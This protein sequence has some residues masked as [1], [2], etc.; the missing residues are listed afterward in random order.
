MY[1]VPVPTSQAAAVLHSRHTH[2]FC[3][4]Q[5]KRNPLANTKTNVKVAK[6]VSDICAIPHL[7]SSCRQLLPRF[8]IFGFPILASRSSSVHRSWHCHASGTSSPSAMDAAESEITSAL[9]ESDGQVNDESGSSVMSEADEPESGDPPSRKELMHEALQRLQEQDLE[10]AMEKYNLE[11]ELFAEIDFSRIN[12]FTDS[13]F[14]GNPAVVCYLPLPRSSE[15][16]QLIAHEFNV[17]ATAFLVKRRVPT[18]K[19]K[20][21]ALPKGFGAPKRPPLLESNEEGEGLKATK[22]VVESSLKGNEFDLR[23]FSSTEELQFCGHATLA[24]AHLLFSA[25][26]IE[27]DTVQFHTQKGVLSA[28]RVNDKEGKGPPSPGPDGRGPSGGLGPQNPASRR[29]TGR[30]A[31]VLDLPLEDVREGTKEETAAVREALPGVDVKWVGRSSL[32][33]LVELASEADI[34][35]FQ[36]G[37]ASVLLAPKL[38]LDG[39]HRGFSVTAA[40]TSEKGND[41]VSRFF[42]PGPGEGSPKED[43]VTGSVHCALAGHWAKRLSKNEGLQAYQASDRG[44]QLRLSVNWESKR[45]SLEGSALIV[46]AGVLFNT[47]T[48]NMPSSSPPASPSSPSVLSPSSP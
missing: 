29:T 17:P 4:L 37:Q 23:W 45:V 31:Y 7:D 15:W 21:R 42:S 11:E 34:V 13:P 19:R 46:M 33:L 14:G 32:D 40:A 1:S 28:Q 5:S 18:P 2:F 44:G 43:P 16:M 27:E 30:G 24:S 36:P 20:G 39:T 6:N 9:K 3:S 26:L 48:T 47:T 8:G 38:K 22:K 12:A 25:G 41:F 35:R 10:E